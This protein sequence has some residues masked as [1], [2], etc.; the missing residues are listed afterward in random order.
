MFSDFLSNFLEY[1]I[2]YKTSFVTHAYNPNI[3]K[4]ET[5]GSEVV[6]S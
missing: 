3:W 5:G 6:A 4:A 2:K 1:H